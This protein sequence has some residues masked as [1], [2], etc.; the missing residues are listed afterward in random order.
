MLELAPAGARCDDG[1]ISSGAPD[2]FSDLL[3]A[4]QI[5]MRDNVAS[6]YAVP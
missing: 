3:G 5:V 2:V 1:P 4:Y 6:R